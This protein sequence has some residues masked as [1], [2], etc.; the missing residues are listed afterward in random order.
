MTNL[1]KALFERL[2][3]EEETAKA[4]RKYISETFDSMVKMSDA[5]SVFEDLLHLEE[6]DGDSYI[7]MDTISKELTPDT[8][9][10][11]YD[12]FKYIIDPPKEEEKGAVN[13]EQSEGT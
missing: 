3:E 11:A 10:K 4:H 5:L 6:I 9:A 12:Y 7:T 8:F 1:E 13:G 2:T